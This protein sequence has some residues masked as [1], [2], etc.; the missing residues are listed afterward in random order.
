MEALKEKRPDRGPMLGFLKTSKS[1][2]KKDCQGIYR[3][4]T[5]L[6]LADAEV[7]LPCVDAVVS[8]IA[9]LKYYYVPCVFCFLFLFI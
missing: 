9:R 3:W 6:R 8:W 2:T 5:D 1:A 4:L 7:Q